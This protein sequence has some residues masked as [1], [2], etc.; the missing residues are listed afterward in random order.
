MMASPEYFFSF[1]KFCVCGLLGGK[2]KNGLKYKILSVSL[3]SGT[4]VSYHHIKSFYLLMFQMERFHYNMRC[5]TKD[6]L[7]L[8]GIYNQCDSDYYISYEPKADICHNGL[9]CQYL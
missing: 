9:H 7:T 3:C 2:R 5:R 1:L 8:E 4:R 6:P